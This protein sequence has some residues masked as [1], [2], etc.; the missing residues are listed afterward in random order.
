MFILKKLVSPFLLPMPICFVLMAFGLLLLWFSRKQIAGK[1]FLSIG[2]FILFLFSYSIPSNS[3]TA[4]LEYRYPP[5]LGNHTIQDVKWVVVLGGGHISDARLPATGQISPPSL[6]RLIEGIRIHKQM[7]GSKLILSGGSGFDPVSNAEV[8]A[9]VA[10]GLGLAE[11]ELVL[12]SE[13]KD[14]K[15]QALLL[16]PIIGNEP[17][18]LVTSATHM[19]RS[20]ALF[21]KL[22]MNPV[23]APTDYTVKLPNH[24]S[25]GSFFPRGKNIVKAERSIHEYLGIVWAKIQG[26]I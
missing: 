12:E 6:F 25:P 1:F 21:Q 13:S 17:F 11:N 16:K 22:G 19:P 18:V 5:L 15:D 10:L 7:N 2:F 3:I 23:P 4:F 24:L 8:M 26:Q 9:R 20:M 14:T